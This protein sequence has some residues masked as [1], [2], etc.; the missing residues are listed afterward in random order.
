MTSHKTQGENHRSLNNALACEVMEVQKRTETFWMGH[1]R[2]VAWRGGRGEAG[3]C[4]QLTRREN[5][6]SQSP[7]TLSKPI[8]LLTLRPRLAAEGP[9]AALLGTPGTN[10]A[11][12]DPTGM[13]T[14]THVKQGK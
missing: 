11:L 2:K 8:Y 13:P 1:S 5:K 7:S 12:R 9:L 6:Q 10:P 4:C 14:V 3:S